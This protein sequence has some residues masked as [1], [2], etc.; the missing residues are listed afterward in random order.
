MGTMIDLGGQRFGELT[1]IGRA[2]TTTGQ[3]NWLCRC[4][5]GGTRIVAGAQLRNGLASRCKECNL[6]TLTG[7]R[8]DRWLVLSKAP[9]K[10][11]RRWTCRCDCG[12]VR[13]VNS[14]ELLNGKSRSCGCLAIE[15]MQRSRTKHGA[16]SNYEFTREYR[17]WKA[18]KTRCLN[19]RAGNY[20]FY[21]GRGITICDR[22]RDS[23]EAFLSDMG[24]CPPEHSIE[25]VNND[26]PYSPDNCRWATRSDQM[27]NRRDSAYRRHATNSHAPVGG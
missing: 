3:A 4:S 19:P 21:G 10:G 18:M 27:R 22:W 8:F 1:V 12:T 11:Y 13:D 23:F 16:A 25:R 2:P 20:A 26:G 9:S 15:G 6:P 24:P 14:K 5:C 7:R 17:T